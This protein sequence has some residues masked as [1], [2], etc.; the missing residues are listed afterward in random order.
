MRQNEVRLHHEHPGL[1]EVPLSK[2]AALLSKLAATG[3][4]N[5]TITVRVDKMKDLNPGRVSALI[6][7]MVVFKFLNY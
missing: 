3:G 4:K 5:R 2:M 7:F 6:L 1:M